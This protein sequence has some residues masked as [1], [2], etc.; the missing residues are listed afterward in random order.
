MTNEKFARMRKN[1][2]TKCQ[3]FR[4]CQR[5]TCLNVTHIPA[6]KDRKLSLRLSN[7]RILSET[8]WGAGRGGGEGEKARIPPSPNS[9]NIRNDGR[10]L[11]AFEGRGAPLP[12]LSSH[13]PEHSSRCENSTFELAPSRM[14]K[15][16]AAT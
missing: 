1:R 11:A 15:V 2:K 5:H 10:V 3:K 9:G 13:T 16:S 14:T 4:M 6:H 8:R 7:R 12:P